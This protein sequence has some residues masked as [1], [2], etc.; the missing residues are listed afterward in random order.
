MSL[1]A[2]ISVNELQP[3]TENGTLG[4]VTFRSFVY[5]LD[6]EKNGVQRDTDST[7]S[8]ASIIALPRSLYEEP[9]LRWPSAG[10]LMDTY[11]TK[12]IPVR[13]SIYVSS[14]V[15]MGAAEYKDVILPASSVHSSL[16]RAYPS[17]PLASPRGPFLPLSWPRH[18]TFQD[19]SGG[20]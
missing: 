7:R 14:K 20:R 2:I 1:S 3:T 5:Q 4:N 19:K 10:Y 16:R 8:S 11:L 9:N 12:P 13:E 6:L 18:E 15:T 17:P